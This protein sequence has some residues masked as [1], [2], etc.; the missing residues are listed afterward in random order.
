MPRKGKRSQAAKQR[1]QPLDLADQPISPSTQQTAQPET[2]PPAP[3]PWT[4]TDAITPS[5]SPAQ[6]F[7]LLV[8]DSHLRAIADGFVAMPD[9]AL[10]FG[11]LSIP[12][13][14]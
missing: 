11:V 1:W 12:G 5:Q 2:P 7:V 13:V 8:G 4:K 3:S 10:S 6:K 9:G 14:G